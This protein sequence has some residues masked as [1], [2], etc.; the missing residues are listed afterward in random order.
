MI[1]V[2]DGVD[3]WLEVARLGA[4]AKTNQPTIVRCYLNLGRRDDQLGD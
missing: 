3:G 2:A 1:E 4:R